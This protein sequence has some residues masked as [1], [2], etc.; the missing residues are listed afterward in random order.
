MAKTWDNVQCRFSTQNTENDRG[1]SEYRVWADRLLRNAPINIDRVGAQDQ[2]Y[3]FMRKA[4]C[5]LDPRSQ[6]L[7]LIMKTGDDNQIK[8]ASVVLDTI[9]INVSGTTLPANRRPANGLV[10]FDAVNN[11]GDLSHIHVGHE[12]CN[13]SLL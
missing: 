11:N 9:Y 10:T 13:L 5:Y 2:V 8:I 3:N 1:N 12:V 7:D 4:I 6:L